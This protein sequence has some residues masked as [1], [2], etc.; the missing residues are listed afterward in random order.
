MRIYRRFVEIVHLLGGGGFFYAASQADLENPEE[1]PY[2]DKYL[3]GRPG[4][5]A[6]DRVRLFKLAWAVTG[7]AFA[8]RVTQYVT[9]Y[10]GDPVRLNAAST[11]ATTRSRSA[12]SS[13]GPWASAPTSISQSRR[14]TQEHPCRVDRPRRGTSPMPIRLPA[15]RSPGGPTYRLLHTG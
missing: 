10:S 8:Q 1:R 4:I 5:S 14:P 12:R 7:S 13:T 15:S 2:I 3:R 9:F 6:E 11:L